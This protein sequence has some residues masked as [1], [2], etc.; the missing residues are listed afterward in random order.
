METHAFD[1]EN[2]RGISSTL[3]LSW[4][5]FSWSSEVVDGSSENSVCNLEKEPS[6]TW[7]VSKL[8]L[9]LKER[10]GRLAGKK[11]DLVLYCIVLYIYLNRIIEK[12]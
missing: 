3:S 9:F 7:T 8:W 11:S 5:F 2:G 10:G 6:A 1:T 12:V 4:T